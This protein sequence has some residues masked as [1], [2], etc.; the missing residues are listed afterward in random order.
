[1]L[2]PGEG[3][4]A[5]SHQDWYS[6]WVGGG[7]GSSSSSFIAGGVGSSAAIFAAIIRPD[8]GSGPRHPVIPVPHGGPNSVGVV[9]ALIWSSTESMG[10]LRSARSS[11]H[12]RMG[13]RGD[14][15]W[16]TL[17]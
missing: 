4:V 3:A 13:K 15:V 11:V 14:Y 16:V 6:L 5:F 10:T 17:S 1:L 8:R 12:K 7:R 9:F 2:M